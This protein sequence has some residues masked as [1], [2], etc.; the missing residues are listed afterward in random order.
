LAYTPAMRRLVAA[1]VIALVVA[2]LAPLA[3]AQEIRI[4]PDPGGPT[5]DAAQPPTQRPR[6]PFRHRPIPF[7][8]CCAET[9]YLP[10]QLP[11]PAP[12]AIVNVIPAQPSLIYIPAPKFEAAPEVQLPSGRWERHGNG[13]EYPYTWVWVGIAGSPP[14]SAGLSR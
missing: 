10:A 12:P 13:K 5:P 7:V 14:L 9:A 11:P 4:G 2:A 6:P 8:T 1:A 3:A